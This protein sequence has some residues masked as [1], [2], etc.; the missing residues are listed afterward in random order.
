ML[1]TALWAHNEKNPVVEASADILCQDMR[2]KLSGERPSDSYYRACSK[3]ADQ[4]I[5]G[6]FPGL[7]DIPT[8]DIL[9]KY[10]SGKT[11]QSS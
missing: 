5:A 4:I 2:R 10:E 6:G 1:V 8:Q 9:F 11:S 3:L 7:S